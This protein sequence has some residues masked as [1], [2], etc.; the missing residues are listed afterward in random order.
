MRQSTCVLQPVKDE[1]V[2]QHQQAKVMGTPLQKREVQAVARQ[3]SWRG[4]ANLYPA[5]Q[6]YKWDVFI[7]HAGNGADKPFALALYEMLQGTGW[8][9]RVFLDD[10]SLQCA[11]NGWADIMAAADS[12][13]V[14]V[15]LFS[16]EYFERPA[17]R[18]EL[19]QL[20]ARH[21]RHH[22]EL[23]P[24]FLRLSVEECN[25]RTAAELGEGASVMQVVLPGWTDMKRSAPCGCLYVFG[26]QAAAVRFMVVRV[27]A[28]RF[29]L[30]NG[31]RHM[32][33]PSTLQDGIYK[34]QNETL[35]Q[36]VHALS[37]LLVKDFHAGCSSYARMMATSPTWM[38]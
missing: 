16:P 30:P 18:A 4:A 10:R 22:V 25:V 7:S 37:K 12:T 13:A 31:I 23:L 36:I 38:A 24:V 28:D 2:P 20:I 19:K 8:G 3:G 14:A 11:R 1:G 6:T 32:G 17:T 34:T 33:E 5:P 9:L 35:W 26:T 15:L 29:R 21:D 27:C